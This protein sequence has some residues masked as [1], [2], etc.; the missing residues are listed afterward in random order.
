MKEKIPS[1]ELHLIPNSAHMSNIENAPEFNKH[2][3]EFLQKIS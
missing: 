1:S 2:L 3:L